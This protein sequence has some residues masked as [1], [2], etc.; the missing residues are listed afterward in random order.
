MTQQWGVGCR[1]SGVGC[2]G[3]RLRALTTCGAGKNGVA[4]IHNGFNRCPWGALK[5]S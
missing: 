2:R 4:C 3:E 1:V 5:R